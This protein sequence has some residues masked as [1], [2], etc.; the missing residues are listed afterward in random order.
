MVGGSVKRAR[1]NERTDL[2]PDGQLL[3]SIGSKSQLRYAKSAINSKDAARWARPKVK[4][5]KLA[6]QTHL[7]CQIVD[8]QA[9]Y[10]KPDEAPV[11]R[12]N[13]TAPGYRDVPVMRVYGVTPE[14]HSANINCWNFHPYFFVEP[15]HLVQPA[16][17]DSRNVAQGC[18]QVCSLLNDFVREKKREQWNN[19]NSEPTAQQAATAA[20]DTPPNK[21]R[22]TA[23]KTNQGRT[24]DA[25]FGNAG[26]IT[27]AQK[28]APHPQANAQA[29]RGNAARTAPATTAYDGGIDDFDDDGYADD[30]LGGLDDE[31]DAS[32][33]YRRRDPGPQVLSV[34]PVIRESADTRNK[35]Q[36]VY[37]KV[38][39]RTANTI[40]MLRGAIARK[41]VAKNVLKPHTFESGV[42]FVMR[43]MVDKLISGSGWMRVPLA[44]ADLVDA[45]D[46][47]R[48]S[49]R[50]QIE[51]NCDASSI[52]GL[53]MFDP[54]NARLYDSASKMRVASYDIEV[55]PN[56]NHDFPTPEK[57]P[58]IQIA[59][60][61]WEVGDSSAAAMSN[62]IFGIGIIDPIP[63]ARVVQCRDER[64]LLHQWGQYCALLDPDILIG[65]NNHNFDSNFLYV[66][67]EMLGVESYLHSSRALYKKASRRKD[68]RTSS[69]M[70]NVDTYQVTFYGRVEY[71]LMKFFQGMKLRSYRLNNVAHDFLGDQ[72]H[73]LD[74]KE[75][76]KLQEGTSRQRQRLAR[77]TL[78]DVALP[79]RLA[80]KKKPF[81]QLFELSR[82][83]FV[84]MSD[85]Q[86]AGST[87]KSYARVLT[88]T[89]AQGF[90]IPYSRDHAKRNYQGAKVLSS[91]GGF[92]DKPVS[93]LDFGSLYPSIMM[94]YNLGPDTFITEA[95]AKK[96]AP[97][98]YY[99]CPVGNRYLRKHVRKSVINQTL[100][101]ILTC[102]SRSKKMMAE[103]AARGDKEEEAIHNERQLALKIV[104][105]TVYGF[106]GLPNNGIYWYWVSEST[107]AIGR[108]MLGVIKD[109]VE[110]HFTVENGYEANAQ[111][112]YG[113]T[114]SIMINWNL[115]V[116]KNQRLS[117]PDPEGQVP[118]KF[119]DYAKKLVQRAI[120]LS[121]EACGL[122]NKLLV[123][124]NKLEFENV[125]LPYLLCADVKKRYAGPFWENAENY[126]RI[127]RRGLESERRDNPLLVKETQLGVLDDI[128]LG[129][130][131][132][133]ALRRVKRAIVD[134]RSGEMDLSK[135]VMSQTLK[136]RAYD[137][138]NHQPHAELDK[139]SGYKYD[140]GDRVPY[141]VVQKG[142]E[143]W[144]KQVFFRAE[145]PIDVLQYNMQP[146]LDFY[147]DRL[148]GSMK[149]I[150]S[151]I[152]GNT[153]GPK[154]VRQGIANLRVRHRAEIVSEHA[155]KNRGSLSAFVQRYPPCVKCGVAVKCDLS[156]PYE[157]RPRLCSSCAGQESSRLLQE[158]QES[159]AALNEQTD[160]LWN[161]CKVCQ[162]VEEEDEQDPLEC[163]AID[164]AIFF[165]RTKTLRA[166]NE[167]RAT[168]MGLE[169]QLQNTSL[170]W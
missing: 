14:G 31:T 163:A 39:L 120:D 150:M 85:I 38:T 137:Y 156:L 121:N 123:K 168:V 115:P 48:R 98:D 95:E 15:K 148:A 7:E 56:K 140:I 13:I 113:D 125:Y 97:E 100:D 53:N 65:W 6:Q 141:I 58:V 2:T 73:D 124:P 118:Y 107:T 19:R 32:A 28:Q 21:R 34:E 104:A 36:R 79:K 51:V 74:Y 135:F 127:K 83:N 109:A 50:T 61:S 111:V 26:S 160:D 88:Q 91:I 139:R 112:I 67:A 1:E 77:Y 106:T 136:K 69:N 87:M 40:Y 99:T 82:V 145:S 45:G 76:P 147:M 155:P 41:E 55:K 60:T 159:L 37:L 29:A 129:M 142:K 162:G 75:I 8:V 44:K 17:V 161:R 18:S 57:D 59:V 154:K 78:Q 133:A 33:S 116:D 72:K 46:E 92:Y 24:L 143:K 108:Q 119:T 70:G 102:R 52:E 96:Y 93:V 9:D 117:V 68:T 47:R 71:D 25:Y 170:S 89:R 4:H 169:K 22:K 157:E 110:N 10:V 62:V 11:P 164:C 128:V 35:R 138:K 86:G 167:K 16:D 101:D 165:K 54:A 66:R 63:G 27:Q 64:D 94:A 80:L 84:R 166:R 153:E 130:D 126:S 3:G 30:D 158:C 103:A 151:T 122:C 81:G 132:E 5:D 146:D 42:R 134:M 12:S 152:Y 90:I 105:N 43:F 114:D 20:R 49:S 144:R 149:R 23:Q 131:P